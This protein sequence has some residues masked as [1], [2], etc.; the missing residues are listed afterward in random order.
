MDKIHWESQTSHTVPKTSDKIAAQGGFLH[1]PHQ[2][3]MCTILKSLSKERKPL[4]I[5]SCG[6]ER[7]IQPCH[8]FP[9]TFS[10]AHCFPP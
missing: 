9:L 4:Q 2:D 10:T 8:F 3:K 5:L 7:V 6:K 1:Q